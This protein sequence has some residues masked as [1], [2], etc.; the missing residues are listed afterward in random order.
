MQLTH[1]FEPIFDESSRILILGTFPSVK[2]RE[3]GFYYGHPQNRF[4]KI[5]ARITNTNQ[6]PQTIADKKLMLLANKIALSDVLQSCD[7]KGSNDSSI[8]NTVPAGLFKILNNS[9]IDRIYANGEKAYQLAIK[10]FSSNVTQK[11]YKLPSTS[12]ANAKYSLEK[13]ILE[14]KIIST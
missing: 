2:S 8:K 5:I 4:W 7:I 9:N 12:P 1:P 11:I 14:W 6:I 10:Y 13:L 3:H